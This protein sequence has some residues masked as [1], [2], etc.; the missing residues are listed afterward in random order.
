M[1]SKPN[2]IRFLMFGTRAD[3]AQEDEGVKFLLDVG[4]YVQKLANQKCSYQLRL[5]PRR[6]KVPLPPTT[7]HLPPTTH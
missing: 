6:S 4:F 7:Y 5:T 3:P 1:A 2:N